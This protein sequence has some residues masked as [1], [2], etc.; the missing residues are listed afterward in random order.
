MDANDRDLEARRRDLEN[1]P[2]DY[3]KFVNHL[4]D[5]VSRQVEE[6]AEYTPE[7]AGLVRLL[8]AKSDDAKEG[9]LQRALTLYGIALDS[10][11]KGNRLVIL[12]SDDFILHEVVGFGPAEV[13]EAETIGRGG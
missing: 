13:D 5:L 11:E 8:A 10:R 7:I 12:D 1:L 2:D 4:M 6:S 3:I 9:V